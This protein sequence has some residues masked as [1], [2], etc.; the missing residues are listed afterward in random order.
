MQ[1]VESYNWHIALCQ[2]GSRID[3]ASIIKNR[4]HVK[5]TKI[6]MLIARKII[7]DSSHSSPLHR[8]TGQGKIAFSK[9]KIAVMK[10]PKTAKKAPPFGA[11]H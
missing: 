3:S 7:C 4:L 5:R 10:G 9:K 2:G 1:K 11:S 8:P 6:R